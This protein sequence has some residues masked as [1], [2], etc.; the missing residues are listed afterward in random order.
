MLGFEMRAEAIKWINSFVLAFSYMQNIN[1][2]Y[3]LE[4]EK[5]SDFVS[6]ILDAAAICRDVFS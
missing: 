5:I 4:R 1:I 6:G 2:I 3:C